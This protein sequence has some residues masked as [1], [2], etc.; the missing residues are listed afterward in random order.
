VEANVD[1]VADNASWRF[2]AGHV[3]NAESGSKFT[4]ELERV[5]GVPAFVS[6]FKDGRGGIRKQP[7]KVFEQ[8]EV[9]V[10]AWR[11]LIKDWSEAAFQ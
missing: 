2:I 7:D 10:E 6:K 5:S 8:V 1:Y 9:L 4:K 3:V 11:Q